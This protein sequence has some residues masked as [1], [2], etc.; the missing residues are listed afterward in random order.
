MEEVESSDDLVNVSAMEDEEID[1]LHSELHTYKKLGG[2]HAI[3]MPPP[4]PT[5]PAVAVNPQVEGDEV[6][7]TYRYPSNIKA[8]ITKQL[9]K[10]EPQTGC[11][12]KT[13]LLPPAPPTAVVNPT[14]AVGNE[15]ILTYHSMSNI[16]AKTI[17]QLTV[18]T[19]SLLPAPSM[20]A[21][22]PT[23][24]KADSSHQHIVTTT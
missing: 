2:K 14:P 9:T 20:A 3:K 10:D 18:K 5:P 23:L 22:S 7:S 17:P 11:T 19:P 13:L 4:P 8:K 1:P 6:M 12:I 21:V 24:A 16:K 15:A